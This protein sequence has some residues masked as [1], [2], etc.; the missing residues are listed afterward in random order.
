MM[1][2]KY[3]IDPKPPLIIAPSGCV[4][5]S[6]QALSRNLAAHAAYNPDII[7]TGR[8]SEMSARL[9]DILEQRKADLLVR[10]MLWGSEILP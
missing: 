10:S 7:T 3:M 4:S 1:P 9:R 8:R 2:K 5:L 6:A